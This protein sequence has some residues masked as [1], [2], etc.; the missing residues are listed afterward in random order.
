MSYRLFSFVAIAAVA[1][2]FA[3][4]KV[5]AET[6]TLKGKFVAEGTVAAPALLAGTDKDGCNKHKL[7]DEKVVAS[8]KGEIANVFVYSRTKGLTAPA[9]TEPEVLLDN[10]NCRFE[11]HCMVYRVGQKL[12]LQNSDPFGH[13]SNI[14]PFNG[15]AVNPLI[16][17]NS[18]Q[19]IEFKTEESLP[20]KVGCNIHPWMGAWV[21]I[22]KDPFA[23]VSAKDGTFEIKDLPVGKDIEFQ[24]WQESAGNLKSLSFT[25]G[26]TDTKGR[27]KVKLKAGDN[28]L[29]EIKIPVAAFK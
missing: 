3:A 13:N 2:L 7:V 22:R 29:G 4:D 15:S 18:S 25:G 6:A 1:S 28:D 27:Y 20:T 14:Q 19:T 5:V 10:K 17:Q 23:A 9:P 12:K 8:D 11:P 21:L 16:P 24:F 26:K